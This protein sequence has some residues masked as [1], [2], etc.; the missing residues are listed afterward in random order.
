VLITFYNYAYKC[1]LSI[2]CIQ[3]IQK[4][5]KF[6]S[7]KLGYGYFDSI[8]SFFDIHMSVHQKYITKIIQKDATFSRSIYFY[9]LLY[10]FQAVPPSITRSTKLYIQPQVLSNQY[11]C[12]LL[13]GWDGTESESMETNV[14]V[15]VY[16]FFPSPLNGYYY[17]YYYYF[18]I[19]VVMFRFCLCFFCSIRVLVLAL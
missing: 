15:A 19:I 9:K 3:T 17:C 11:C 12:L 6:Q 13:S 7:L 8:F 18:C 1:L 4:N 16:E 10:M 14:V 2:E 5:E